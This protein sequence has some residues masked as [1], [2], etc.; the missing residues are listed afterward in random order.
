MT[1]F[2]IIQIDEKIATLRG[3]YPRDYSKSNGVGIADALIA[4][5]ANIKQAKLVTLNR[6]HFPIL[7]DLIIP[8]QKR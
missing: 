4:A 5:T 2:E 1:A 7:T 8:D 6:K 3:L